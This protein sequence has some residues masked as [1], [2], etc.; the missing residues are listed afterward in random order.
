MTKI[1]IIDYG[2]GNLRSV[3]RGV[4]RAGARSVITHDPE[5]ISAADSIIL[6]GVGA[7]SEGM[8]RLSPVAQTI[9]SLADNRPLLGICLGMQMLMETSEE[10]GDHA[11]LSLVPGRVLRFQPAPGIKI[12][13]MGWNRVYLAA[14]DD[15]LFEG[16]EDGS[17]FYFVHSYYVDCPPAYR[18]CETEYSIRYASA[19]KNKRIYGVQF[20]PEKSSET[21]LLLLQNF[22]EMA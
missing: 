22:I 11:G 6:P 7:F 15:P 13:H 5:E 20:H 18:L 17:Y 12:P 19:V 16:I 1:A 14:E 9:L 3:Y 4:E 21:G 2:L 10:H 8:G